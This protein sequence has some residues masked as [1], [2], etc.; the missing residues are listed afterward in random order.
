MSQ[1]AFRDRGVV[2][3]LSESENI[4][5]THKTIGIIAL[6]NYFYLSNLINFKKHI[7]PLLYYFIH[8]ID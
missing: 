4:I 6:L 8:K 3:F 5:S 7:H 1:S 2:S